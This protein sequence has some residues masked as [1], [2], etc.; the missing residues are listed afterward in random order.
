MRGE[1]MNFSGAELASVEM[2][3]KTFLAFPCEH[4][5]ALAEA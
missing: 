1:Q 2:K 5:R 4:R 3:V